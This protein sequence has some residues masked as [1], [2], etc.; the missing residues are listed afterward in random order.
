MISELFD[1]KIRT[2]NEH[3]KKNDVE[4]VEEATVRKNRIV[5]KEGNG[6]LTEKEL[7]SLDRFVTMYLDYAEN[8]ADRNIPMTM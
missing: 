4:L 2:I 6:E 8:Q 1:V 3:L 7:K 5:Q